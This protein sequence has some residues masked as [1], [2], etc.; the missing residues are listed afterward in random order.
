MDNNSTQVPLQSVKTSTP[1]RMPS[2]TPKKSK[3]DFIR[4]FARVYM[5]VNN[6]PGIVL[7]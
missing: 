7:N 5:P 1:A 4:Q 3:L 2:A 6:M